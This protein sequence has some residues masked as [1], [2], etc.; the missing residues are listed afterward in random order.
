[1]CWWVSNLQLWYNTQLC[2]WWTHIDEDKHN[3]ERFKTKGSY[4][5]RT[6]GGILHYYRGHYIWFHNSHMWLFMSSLCLIF[7]LFAI[8]L[9]FSTFV[10]A[11]VKSWESCGCYLL[12]MES[13]IDVFEMF[14]SKSTH[15]LSSPSLSSCLHGTRCLAPF[16]QSF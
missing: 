9:T 3:L 4:F 14:L 5:Y 10:G 16:I 8:I 12:A 11:F 6:I 13:G 2:S 7:M 15:L 1:L